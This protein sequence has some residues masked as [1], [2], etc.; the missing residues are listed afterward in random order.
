MKNLHRSV[1]RRSWAGGLAWW[2][3][4]QPAPPSQPGV[5]TAAAPAGLK[6]RGSD[7]PATVEVAQ[8]SRMTLYDDARAVGSL[9]STQGVMLR[10]EASGRISRLG[11]TEGERVKRGQLMV[12]LDDALQRAAVAEA[13]ASGERAPLQRRRTA[14]ASFISQARSSPERRGACVQREGGEEQG[15]WRG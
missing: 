6:G 8:A 13:Q 4:H 3:Q 14:G 15:S 12:Q 1:R 2:W 5:T 7:G 11:F 10:P 9:K